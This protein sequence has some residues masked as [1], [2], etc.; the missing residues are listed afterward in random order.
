MRELRAL[1][2][3]DA[4]S[5]PMAFNTT[6]RAVRL[7][8][9]QSYALDLVVRRTAETRSSHVRAAITQYLETYYRDE[10]REGKEEA[11]R[12]RVGL[13]PVQ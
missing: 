2:A 12:R 6:S 3:Y 4:L 11:E 13:P 5:L 7:H 8:R 10:M 9:W 1:S